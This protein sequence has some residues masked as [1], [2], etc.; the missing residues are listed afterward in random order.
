M[1]HFRI[2][3]IRDLVMNR[4]G[5]AHQGGRIETPADD[6]PAARIGR[7]LKGVDAPTLPQPRDAADGSIE[8]GAKPVFV[9]AKD[10]ASVAVSRTGADSADAAAIRVRDAG[11]RKP[12]PGRKF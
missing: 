1:S 6:R 5:S 8:I 3:Q 12:A 7:R 9:P 10:G 2:A 4:G 11:A